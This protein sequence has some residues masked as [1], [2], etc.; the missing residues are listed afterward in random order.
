MTVTLNP[1]QPSTSA[2]GAATGP[3]P[4]KQLDQDSFLQLLVSQLKNQDPTAQSAQ[5]PNQMVQQLTSFSMLQQNE[6]TNSLLSAIQGQNVSLLGTQA[7]SLMGKQVQLSGSGFHLANGKAVMGLDLATDANVVL[8][9]KDLNGNTVATIPEGTLKSGSNTLTWDGTG[10][11]GSKLPDGN[12]T[13]SVQAKDPTG[14]DVTATPSLYVTVDAVTYANGQ[15]M[16]QSGGVSF[17]MSDVLK[18]LA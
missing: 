11:N 10:T 18:I 13:V 9:V 12:Y 15:V 1:T 2:T 6:Q 16:L 4:K 3:N 17:S 7:A 8:T 14:K 5:D